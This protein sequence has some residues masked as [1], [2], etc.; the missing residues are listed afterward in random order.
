MTTSTPSGRPAGR[1]IRHSVRPVVFL[2][3]PLVL[4][5]AAPAAAQALGPVQPSGPLQSPVPPG[6]PL[7]TLGPVGLTPRLALRDFGVDSNVF[8]DAETPS[9]DMVAVVVPGLDAVMQVGAVR[10]SSR[11]LA[12]WNHFQRSST[13]RSVNVN[14]QGRVA[15]DL[16]RVS[17]YL[18]VGYLRSRHR[19]NLEI[20]ERVL[21]KARAVAAGVLV[22][23]GAQTSLDVG[24]RRIRVD[25]GDRDRGSPILADRLN[26]RTEQTRMELRRALSSLTSLTFVGEHRRDRFE[27]EDVRDSDHL[28]VIAGL[29]LKPSA[30]ISGTA[31]AGVSQL[32]ARHAS[33]PDHTDLVAAVQVSYVLLEQ[34][35]FSV[36]FDREVDYSFE[37]AWPYFV[38]TGALVEIKQAVGFVW[39]VVAR[40]GRSELSYQPFRTGAGAVLAGRR[41]RTDIVGVG[42]GRHLGDQI[43][44]GVD[45]NRERRQSWDGRTQGT[46]SEA[47]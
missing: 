46:G 26:R 11:T 40:A 43:R 36:R 8:N 18:D 33:M 15:L 34:T 29:E 31:S 22:T 1:P 4:W 44:V 2:I 28:D 7:L 17:P 42:A 16:T 25:F 41:D 14:Q 13:Q 9:R 23:L 39:D 38:A 20:D 5:L 30:L 3:G 35:R 47:R 24:Y 12:E 19:P 6:E 21:Q 32:R 27:F 37:T 10:L 45:L